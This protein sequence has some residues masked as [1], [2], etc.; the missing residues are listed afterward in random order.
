MPNTNH[1]T[2]AQ[3]A[4]GVFSFLSD[5]YGYTQ[6]YLQKIPHEEFACIV[7]N[8]NGEAKGKAIGLI[9]INDGKIVKVFL[10]N[11]AM[12][13]VNGSDEKP[14][15]YQIDAGVLEPTENSLPTSKETVIF[16]FGSGNFLDS[17][18]LQRIM[19]EFGSI[20]HF[21]TP[22]KTIEGFAGAYELLLVSHSP[23]NVAKKLST[24]Y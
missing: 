13:Y 17:V 14:I 7:R 4:L 8:L 5:K 3:M 12:P 16:R 24:S 2:L 23:K 22:K 9:S 19:A 6:E 10:F 15:A 11:K 21:V 20:V 18:P 1:R